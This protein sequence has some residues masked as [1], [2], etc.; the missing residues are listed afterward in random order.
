MATPPL[1]PETGFVPTLP[2][3]YVEHI[4]L[5]HDRAY[6]EALEFGAQDQVFDYLGATIRVA[7]GVMPITR[8]SYLLGEQVLAEAGSNDRVLDMGTGSGVNAVLAAQKGARVLAVDVSPKAIDSARANVERNEVAGL[9]E[10]RESDIFSSVGGR[11]DLIVFDPPFR[12]FKP[13]DLVESAMADEGYQALTR[14]VQ[15]A[16]DHLAVDGRMLIFFGTSG[17]LGYLEGLLDEAGFVFEVVARD[18]LIR[19]GWKVEYFTFRVTLVG[20]ET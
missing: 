11:F 2:Q 14:F 5:W 8:M 20:T 3:E 12:W 1:E 17:D 10:V 6:T 7:P 18:E 16:K 9:V 13:R 4:R 19:D 15:A